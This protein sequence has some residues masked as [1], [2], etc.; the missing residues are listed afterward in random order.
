MAGTFQRQQ[1]PTILNTVI[2]YAQHWALCLYV[3][4]Y[5][6]SD[7]PIPPGFLEASFQGYSR[8]LLSSWAPY[9]GST[10]GVAYISSGERK[11]TVTQAPFDQVV[12]GYFLVDNVGL[13][14]GGE[15]LAGD[16][17]AM[18]STGATLTLNV[19]VSLTNAF[20]PPGAGRRVAT[21]SIS[22]TGS[23]ALERKV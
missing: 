18:D 6:P 13:L 1:L 14:V 8:I 15:R 9:P 11:F 16:G 17:F 20:I 7:Y 22:L 5:V 3:N 19:L 2:S 10:Q 21:P 4:D 12:Y 23:A